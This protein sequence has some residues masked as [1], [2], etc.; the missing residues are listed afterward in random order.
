MAND[1][2]QLGYDAVIDV[3][4]EEDHL[5]SDDKKIEEEILREFNADGEEK[6]WRITVKKIDQRTKKQET[7][8]VLSPDEIH[9]IFDK[10]KNEFGPG[11]YRAYVTC[12]NVLK[13]NL[14]YRI[15]KPLE[16][17]AVPQQASQISDIAQLIRQQNEQMAAIMRGQTPNAPQDPMAMFTA[18]MGAIASMKEVFVQP[19]QPAADPMKMTEIFFKGFEMAREVEGGNSSSSVYDVIKEIIRS[20]LGEKIG[21]QISH[22]QYQPNAG[23]APSPTGVPVA[24]PQPIKQQLNAPAIQVQTNARPA[25]NPNPEQ[26]SV[27]AGLQGMPQAFIDQMRGQ[28]KMWADRARAGSDPALYADLALDTYEPQVLQMAILRPDLRE[29]AQYLAP[30]SLEVWPW[31]QQLIEE[32]NAGL[33]QDIGGEDNGR[34]MVNTQ[35]EGDVPDNAPK[36]NP[37]APSGPAA[38]N[39]DGN[40]GRG[41]GHSGNAKTNAKANA[42]G[43]EKSPRKT[44]SPS[45]NAKPKAK[46]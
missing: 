33:T 5:F 18:M 31:F 38:A 22:L 16:T 4:S 21:D 11:V 12:N 25:D 6:E 32:I 23:S 24:R 17:A 41:S 36:S 19:S 3:E 27:P 7:C 28:L 45:R 44:A 43:K 1:H 14:E 42:G 2:K 37:D 26:T 40:S 15:A 13:R 34:G 35:P 29:I 39:P 30:E 10:L 9:S 8:F 46:G 20:P